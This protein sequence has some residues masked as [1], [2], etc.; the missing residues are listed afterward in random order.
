MGLFRKFRLAAVNL[1]RCAALAQ[2]RKVRST[3][4][5]SCAL[6]LGVGGGALPILNTPLAFARG[7]ESLADLAAA[8]SDAVVNISATQTI[9][10][11]HADATPQIEPGTPL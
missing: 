9:D 4:A 5:L 2:R 10:E 7:P 6:V 11:K 1:V 3:I 8:V